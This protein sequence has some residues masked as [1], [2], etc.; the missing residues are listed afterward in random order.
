MG[1]TRGHCGYP[2]GMF[3]LM[4][5]SKLM[6][7]TYGKNAFTRTQTVIL[8]LFEERPTDRSSEIY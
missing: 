1:I 7:S 8:G 5:V 2:G 4:G 3:K 6:G